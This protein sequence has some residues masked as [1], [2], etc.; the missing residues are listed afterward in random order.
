M[1]I[2]G[3]YMVTSK[4]SFT[5]LFRTWGQVF[6]YS[7]GIAAFSVASG[8]IPFESFKNTYELLFLCCPIVMGH[9]WFATAYFILLCIA[10]VLGAA[11]RN[12]TKK[13]FEIVLVCLLSVFC[14]VKTIMPYQMIFDDRG[15]GVLWFRFSIIPMEWLHLHI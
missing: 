4:F 11:A 3:Y 13:Q 2:S 15:N 6:F 9:Y 8:M 7:V 12:L 10:P 14:F 5:K 1:L